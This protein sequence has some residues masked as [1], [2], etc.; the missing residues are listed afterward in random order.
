MCLFCQMI[1]LRN[2]NHVKFFV[3][4]LHDGNGGSFAPDAHGGGDTGGQP[5]VGLDSC[6]KNKAWVRVPSR[7]NNL[8][9][10]QTDRSTGSPTHLRDI[11]S[12]DAFR[13]SST[14]IQENS[15][16][17]HLCRNVYQNHKKMVRYFVENVKVIEGFIK[18]IKNTN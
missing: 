9:M 8:T 4:H 11:I 14:S 12:R 7:G 13:K 17:Q 15:C 10:R 3:V 1:I 5:W 18:K 6:R 2:S 16:V